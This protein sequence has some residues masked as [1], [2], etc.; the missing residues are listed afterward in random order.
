MPQQRKESQKTAA[1]P[2]RKQQ[3]RRP[4][5]PNSARTNTSLTVSSATPMSIITTRTGFFKDGAKASL[6]RARALKGDLRVEAA[7]NDDVSYDPYSSASHTQK[8]TRL[9]KTS[10]TLNAGGVASFEEWENNTKGIETKCHSLCWLVPEKYNANGNHYNDRRGTMEQLQSASVT[11]KNTSDLPLRIHVSCPK[12]ALADNSRVK[13]RENMQVLEVPAGGTVNLTTGFRAAEHKRP[14]FKPGAPGRRIAMLFDYCVLASDMNKYTGAAYAAKQPIV[15]INVTVNYSI[16]S[17]VDPD[18]INTIY[19]AELQTIEVNYY[20]GVKEFLSV[21]LDPVTFAEGY[22]YP[23]PNLNGGR[24]KYWQCRAVGSLDLTNGQSIDAGVGNAVWVL[25]TGV[26]GG[27]GLPDSDSVPNFE[28]EGLQEGDF[29]QLILPMNLGQSADRNSVQLFRLYRTT[30]VYDYSGSNINEL[31]NK[32]V[33]V[34]CIKINSTKDPF[35]SIQGENFLITAMDASTPASTYA[36]KITKQFSPCPLKVIKI[37]DLS[38]EAR[39]AG[40]FFKGLFKILATATKV[41]EVLV[42]FF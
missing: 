19:D 15:D 14:V 41:A 33:A 36:P 10:Y 32:L 13:V 5:K 7:A 35:E 38:L 40:G 29:V 26:D 37:A 18:G 25:D 42:G 11:F 39:D 12:S 8:L 9:D 2:G 30:K 20:P 4:S 21:E 24:P 23:K 27:T 6:E 34:A 31:Y 3:T 28:E 22:I 17:V 16:T 1:R